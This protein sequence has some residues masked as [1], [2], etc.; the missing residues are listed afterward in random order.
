MKIVLSLALI[1][2]VG[3]FGLLALEDLEGVDVDRSPAGLRPVPAEQFIHVEKLRLSSFKP[4]NLFLISNTEAYSQIVIENDLP[5]AVDLDLNLKCDQPFQMGLDPIAPK[6]LERNFNGKFV[7]AYPFQ[8]KNKK[9]AAFLLN[10]KIQSCEL[11]YQ[12]TQGS[13]A[14]S[15]VDIHSESLDFPFLKNLIQSTDSCQVDYALPQLFCPRTAEKLETLETPESGFIAKTEML[16]GQ[17]LDPSFISNQ[18]PYAEIDFSKAPKLDA[19]YIATLVYRADFYG[20]VLARLLKFHADR[21]T[22]VHLVTTSYMMLDKDKALLQKLAADNGNFRLQEFKYYDANYNLI[23]PFRYVISHYRDMH[24]KLFITLGKNK[25]DN[26]V[27]LGGRNI[28]DG[29]LFTTRPDY[30]KYPDLVQYGTDDDFVHWNDFEMK[31][32]SVDV[33]QATAAHLLKFLNRDTMTQDML[34]FY[35]DPTVASDPPKARGQ[36]ELRHFISLPYNDSRTLENLYISLIDQAQQTIRISSPYLRPTDKIFAALERAVDRKVDIVIQTRVSLIGDTQA[37]LYEE[38]NKESINK[39]YD[40]VKIYEWKQNSILHSKFILV[41]GQTAFI[42]SVNLSRR[43]FVHDVENGFI[44]KD[45][46]FIAKMDTIFNSYIAKSDL[47]SKK[48]DRKFWPSMVIRVLK[49]Q[50]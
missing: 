38:V 21:G 20:T 15:M 40:K 32:T 31:I 49:N 43:S 7:N 34:P 4:K 14:P 47:I 36:T 26:A 13:D 39:L 35:K 6:I 24:I 41:D 44:I 1:L 22:L 18:N 37:W 33:A 8:L 10:R 29:F 30:S 25:N 9:T 12:K 23:R 45:R 28:H 19:I 48:E 50:F 42:G 27:V 16:L 11:S 2:L 5:E 3:L 17:K 46:A